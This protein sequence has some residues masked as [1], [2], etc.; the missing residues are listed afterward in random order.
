MRHYISMSGSFGCLPDFCDVSTDRDNA[1]DTL[2]SLFEL[3]KTR[4]RHLDRDGFLNLSP[5]DGAEYCEV[6]SCDCENPNVHSD[7]GECDV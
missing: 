7:S 4:E 6:I 2:V 3:G 1:V 5:R